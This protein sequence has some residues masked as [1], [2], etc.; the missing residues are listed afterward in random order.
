MKRII[1][2]LLIVFCVALAGCSALSLEEED[3]L[4][5]PKASGDESEVISLI[6]SHFS[7]SFKLV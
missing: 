6:A 5:V 7:S 2:I 4:A 3:I 1:A